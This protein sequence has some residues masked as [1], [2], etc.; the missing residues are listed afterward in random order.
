MRASLP[1]LIAAF[2]TLGS[3]LWA[4]DAVSGLNGKV[5][6]SHGDFD[7]FDGESFQ[8]SVALPLSSKWGAQFDGLYNR[9]DGFDFGGAGGHVFWRDSD[10]A[11]VG[12]AAS[13]VDSINSTNYQAGLEAEYYFPWLTVGAFA[14]VGGIRYDVAAPFIDTDRRDF[15]GN[16]YL[17]FYPLPDL[18]IRPKLSLAHQNLG[19]GVELEYALPRYNLAVIA[20]ALHSEHDFQQHQLGLR[21][22]FGGKKTLKARHRED[23]PVSGVADT[24]NALGTYGAEYNQRGK[25]YVQRLNSTSS[26]S[27]VNYSGSYGVTVTANSV[28]D[29]SVP[30]VSINDAGL[31]KS[32]SGTLTLIGDN[33]YT[34]STTVNS[35]TVTL[36]SDVTT[37]GTS[38][39]G[40]FTTG[41]I[42][43]GYL[44]LTSIG[45][46]SAPSAP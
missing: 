16:V 7:S 38:A 33:T 30:V 12:L 42:S 39:L 21:Y 37:A 10:Q 13:V 5:S 4:G 25:A 32:G 46:F 1:K 24:L 23:D 18:L 44:N 9:I 35:G 15:A 3:C 22:Y 40:T 26:G 17:G 41:N 11:L 8:G 36:S 45:S 20:E 34:G 6:A 29:L 14:G 2:A 27:S 43:V 19:Y 31:V 28:G